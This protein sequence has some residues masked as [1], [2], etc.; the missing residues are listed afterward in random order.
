[1]CFWIKFFNR[2]PSKPGEDLNLTLK[3]PC[4]ENFLKRSSCCYYKGSFGNEKK[5]GT[6][7][8]PFS[9][10]V[11]RQKHCEIPFPKGQIIA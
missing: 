7:S 1:M 4:L 10:T 9:N 11:C 6:L 5:T 2:P 8:S 3:K